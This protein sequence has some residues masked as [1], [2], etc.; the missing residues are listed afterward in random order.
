MKVF[1]LAAVALS[2]VGFSGCRK[3][4]CG[5]DDHKN[6]DLQFA[7]VVESDG[8]LSLYEGFR[9]RDK[10]A[11]GEDLESTSNV[12]T[13]VRVRAAAA[14]IEEAR[15]SA[16]VRDSQRHRRIFS[17]ETPLPD[18]EITFHGTDLRLS[19]RV[20]DDR[21]CAR[22]TAEATGAENIDII[23]GSPL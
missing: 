22:L 23:P 10:I 7:N 21:G 18:V 13:F 4:G 12:W 8:R 5:D 14:F 11:A 16:E 15:N 17:L 20:D 2:T 6:D 1:V 3:Y 9:V 19:T